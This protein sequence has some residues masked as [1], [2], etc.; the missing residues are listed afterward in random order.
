MGRGGEMWYRMST[1]YNWNFVGSGSVCGVQD[2][3]L[4]PQVWHATVPLE[5]TV[6]EQTWT[7]V[8][9][10]LRGKLLRSATARAAT[11]PTVEIDPAGGGLGIVAEE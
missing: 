4:A 7:V 10:V 6:D 3:E 11:E 9:V 2:F 1:L 5:V 8:C